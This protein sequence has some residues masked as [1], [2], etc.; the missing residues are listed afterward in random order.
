[1]GGE[2]RYKKILALKEN[3]EFIETELNINPDFYVK[4]AD[5][6]QTKEERDELRI[7]GSW[8]LCNSRNC[9]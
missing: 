1:M 9:I 6:L 3:K 8:L 7:N 4:A 2:A 5:E